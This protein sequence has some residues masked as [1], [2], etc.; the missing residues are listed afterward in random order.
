MNDPNK[1]A[2]KTPKLALLVDT[3]TAKAVSAVSNIVPSTDKFTTPD[4]SEMVSPITTKIKGALKEII[5]IN[6]DSK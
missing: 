1:P 2:D 3:A 4:R 5:V 6:E